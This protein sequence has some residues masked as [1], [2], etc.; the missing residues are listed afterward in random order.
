MTASGPIANCLNAGFMTV[1]PILGH[2]TFNE[3]QADRFSKNSA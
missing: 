3:F 2:L 1:W